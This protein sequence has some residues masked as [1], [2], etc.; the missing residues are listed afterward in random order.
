MEHG[1]E[2]GIDAVQSEIEERGG[3]RPQRQSINDGCKTLPLI[4]FNS[5]L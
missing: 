3:E 2:M 5:Y 4:C 1:A